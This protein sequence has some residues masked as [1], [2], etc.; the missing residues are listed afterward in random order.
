[1]ATKLRATDVPV[2]KGM[3]ALRKYYQPLRAHAS[4]GVKSLGQTADLCGS[5][6]DFWPGRRKGLAGAVAFYVPFIPASSLTLK[7]VGAGRY[8]S[9][10]FQVRQSRLG[11]RCGSATTNQDQS[12][13]RAQNELRLVHGGISESDGRSVGRAETRSDW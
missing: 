13:R 12:P 8:R 11:C 3:A 4:Q 2:D 6:S 1:R 9:S 5:G 7:R 10:G